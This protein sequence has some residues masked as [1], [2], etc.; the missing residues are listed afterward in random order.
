MHH[1]A[2]MTL[3][4]HKLVGGRIGLAGTRLTIVYTNNV[5]FALTLNLIQLLQTFVTLAKNYV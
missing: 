5:L 3:W 2:E 1:L 4:N